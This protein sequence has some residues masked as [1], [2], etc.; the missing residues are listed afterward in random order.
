MSPQLRSNKFRP[1]AISAGGT[2]QS[3]LLYDGCYGMCTQTEFSDV[4][5]RHVRG[6]LFRT[7][8]SNKNSKIYHAAINY[9]KSQIRCK[10]SLVDHSWLMLETPRN[11]RN[12]TAPCA[13]KASKKAGLR[14]LS[15]R[16]H[17]LSSPSK[18]GVHL[19]SPKSPR[20]PPLGKP[21]WGADWLK[22]RGTRTLK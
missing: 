19:Y 14:R 3:V 4:S 13:K 1:W 22:L 21:R 2:P 18:S 7:P 15:L 5:Y 17:M 20:T 9:L 6:I 12:S 16:K 11:V 8:R 10:F